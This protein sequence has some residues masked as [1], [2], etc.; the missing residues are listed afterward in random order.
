[1]AQSYESFPYNNGEISKNIVVCQDKALFLQT[2]I[3]L[4]MKRTVLTLLSL[5][6]LCVMAQDV[7]MTL[8]R[9]NFFYAGQSKQR[10]M[11]V[12]KDGQVAWSYQDTLR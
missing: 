11:F 2:K 12:V 5:F 1:M 10:R 9:H 6:A 3:L 8:D 4:N 7:G